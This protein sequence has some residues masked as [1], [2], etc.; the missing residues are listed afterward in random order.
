M[1]DRRQAQRSR[2]EGSGG[3]VIRCAALVGLLRSR[4]FS[5]EWAVAVGAWG[6]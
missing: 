6:L 2:I 5:L 3:D 1:L 4:W